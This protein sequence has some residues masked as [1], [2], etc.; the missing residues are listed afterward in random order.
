MFFLPV[1]YTWN[2]GNLQIVFFINLVFFQENSIVQGKF[3]RNC[4]MLQQG[5]K[6][7]NVRKSKS[8]YAYQIMQAC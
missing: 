5:K 1:N 6:G 3:F 4:K 7:R 2:S 8:A